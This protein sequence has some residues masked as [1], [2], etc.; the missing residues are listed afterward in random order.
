MAVT[1]RP[2]LVYICFTTVLQLRILLELNVFLWDPLNCLTFYTYRMNLLAALYLFDTAA[3]CFK[4]IDNKRSPKP[5]C[6]D[7]FQLLKKGLIVRSI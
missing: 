2:L 7:N 4:S 6:L 5:H 1:Q 3:T